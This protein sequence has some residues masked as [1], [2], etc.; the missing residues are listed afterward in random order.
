M[1]RLPITLSGSRCL[2]IGFGKIGKALSL[3]LRGLCA[4]VTVS[5]RRPED[6]ALAEALGLQSDRTGVYFRGLRQYDCVFN[7]VPA[8]VLLE[9]HIAALRPDCLIVDLASAPGG[10]AP[11][12]TP[13]ERPVYLT[14]PGLPG[15]VAPAS[16]AKLLKEHILR[17]L[18]P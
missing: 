13:P 14:A 11:G 10:L 5:A 17:T 16:A 18:T 9:E 8:S 7:T 15:R 6:C 2:V 4:E 12:L 1:E 3:R